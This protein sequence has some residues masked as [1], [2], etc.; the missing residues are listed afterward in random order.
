MLLSSIFRYRCPFATMLLRV[1][2]DINNIQRLDLP[3]KPSSL[4]ELKDIICHKLE[5]A[6]GF[7]LQFEDPAFDNQLCNLNDISYLPDDKATL[8]VFWDIGLMPEQEETTSDFNIDSTSMSSASTASFSQ[9]QCSQQW[10][11]SFTVPTFSYEL[12]L[13]LR[14][15]NE[16]YEKSKKISKS[17]S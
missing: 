10:P 11:A 13:R 5:I 16:E 3:G 14:K 9:S 17:H 12:E 8:K 7:T 4:Q 1:V 6:H 15:G 2:L